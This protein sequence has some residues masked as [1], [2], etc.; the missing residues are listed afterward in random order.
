[1]PAHAGPINHI[2][3]I[4]MKDRGEIY[5][6]Q[7]LAT[8][9]ATL[10]NTGSV[11]AANVASHALTMI[12]TAFEP[13][14]APADTASAQLEWDGEGLPTVGA[15]CE[16]SNDLNDGW[17]A[18]DEVLAHT[19]IK[20][21][22]VAVFKRDDR[23]FYSPAGSFRPARTPEQI[24]ADEIQREVQQIMVDAGITDSALKDDPEAWVWAQALYEAGYR[25]QVAP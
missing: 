13:A 20:G 21:A 4:R 15:V 19:V 2:E 18:V 25:R 17:D 11:E 24:A 12:R 23:V 14:T 8:L 5:V 10:L 9:A 3:A 16:V 22:D 6:L 1:V 7:D